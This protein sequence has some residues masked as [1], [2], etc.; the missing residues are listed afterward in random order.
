MITIIHGDDSLTSRKHFLSLKTKESIY[1]DAE[2]LNI[3]ELSQEISGSGLF[4]DSK[5]IL[6]DNLFSKK[7]VKN[8]EQVSDLL[9]IN[10]KLEIFLWSDRLV[11]SKYLK[12]FK[13]PESKVFKL[14]QTIWSFL[15]SIKPNSQNNVFSFQKTL[16]TV[17]IEIVFAMIIRQFR[18]LLGISSNSK[19]NIDEI[20]RLAPWQKSKL[21]RQASLFEDNSLSKIY[22]KLYLIE[23]SIKTGKSNL[24]LEQNI[25]IL[26]SDI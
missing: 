24:T 21:L 7:G 13:N 15:D 3:N 8:I 14:P 25:D 26:L 4:L 19:T 20:K 23:K 11:E 18:L 9:N 6:I 1:F 17:E 16:E 10:K 12:L 2:S 5:V 22:R